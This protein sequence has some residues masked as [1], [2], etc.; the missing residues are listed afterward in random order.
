MAAGGEDALALTERRRPDVVLLDLEMPGLGGLETCAAIR[1]RGDDIEVLI[2]T[3]SEKE[4]DL[5][6]ALR[7]GAAGYLLKDMP[8][9]ELIDAVVEAG[10]GEPRIAPRMAAR[11]L[12]EFATGEP[13]HVDPLLDLSVREREVLGLLAKGYAQPR[14]RRDARRVRS[15]DQDACP[16]YPGEVAVAQSIRGRGIRRASPAVTMAASLSA[17]RNRACPRRMRPFTVPS[18]SRV[19]LAT[20]LWLRPA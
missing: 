16:P 1:D 17:V 4:P 12:R 15:D 5:W 2:L 6:A 18:A 19:V 13:P 10:R 9:A 7:L 14:N 11:M 3:V 8:P 20:S